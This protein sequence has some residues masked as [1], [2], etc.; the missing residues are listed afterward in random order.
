MRSDENHLKRARERLNRL[1]ETVDGLEVKL[2]EL[3]ELIVSAQDGL[4]D[5][6]REYYEAKTAEA[7]AKLEE[8]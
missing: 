6:A 4:K 1:H 7:I 5:T 8:K 2:L 3:R